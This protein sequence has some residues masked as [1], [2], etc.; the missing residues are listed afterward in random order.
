MELDIPSCKSD[1]KCREP[2]PIE[3][4]A[5]L[6]I[7]AKALKQQWEEEKATQKKWCLREQKFVPKLPDWG[8]L[9]KTVKDN[10]PEAR[11]LSREVSITCII[12]YR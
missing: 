5:K 6:A 4:R 3:V 11:N 12:E 1:K 8:F 10:F 7:H 9:T 2:L